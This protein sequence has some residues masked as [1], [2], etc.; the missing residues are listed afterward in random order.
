VTPARALAAALALLTAGWVS[1]F[2]RAYGRQPRARVID[3]A[4]V[5][6]GVYAVFDHDGGT[7]YVDPRATRSPMLLA[8]LAHELAHFLLNHRGASVAQE[9]EANIAA[10]GILVRMTG[11]SEAAALRQILE[12]VAG[13]EQHEAGALAA[14]G[15]APCEEVRRVLARFPAY[16]DSARTWNLP[17]RCLD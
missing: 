4:S 11:Y 2:G 14:I 1:S 13:A 15:H 12:M 7:L 9:V 5:G 16:A 3:L 17:V 8:G 10:V 6:P